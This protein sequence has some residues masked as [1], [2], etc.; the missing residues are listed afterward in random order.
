M[1]AATYGSRCTAKGGLALRRQA[2][3]G[4]GT[5]VV[6]LTGGHNSTS[7]LRLRTR[8]TPPLTNG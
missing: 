7:A 1:W 3:L 5:A 4:S 2:Q 8:A 6:F